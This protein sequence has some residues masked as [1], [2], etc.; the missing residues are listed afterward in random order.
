M[1]S[2]R[3]DDPAPPHADAP[4]AAAGRFTVV[5]PSSTLVILAL[6]N[7]FNYVDR[8][9]L[10][11]LIPLLEAPVAEGGL[12]LSSTEA[13]LLHTA[14]MI[15]HSVAS[16]PL[17][18]LADR[19][20]RTRVI[21]I[22]V[23]LWSLATAA[24]GLAR[25]YSELFIARAAVGIGEAAYAPAASALISERFTPA[26]RARALGVFQ[27]G[28]LVGTA[29]GVVTGGVVASA[30]GWRTAF[31]IVGLPGLI[32]TA[33]AL[34]IYE[35]PRPRVARATARGDGPPVDASIA[36]QWKTP[37]AR[38][39]IVA[40]N[41]AGV[42]ITFFVGAVALWGIAFLL[43]YHF[44]GDKSHLDEATMLFGLVGT[45][46]G[47]AGALSGSIVADRIER[48]RPG[49]GRLTAVGVGALVGAPCAA[50]ALITP[51]LWLALGALAISVYFVSWY[52]GPILAALHDVVAP[53]H[54]AAATGT[55]LFLVHALGDGISP[56]IVGVLADAISLRV[57]L[58]I[59]LV[60]MALGG[61]VAL[62]AVRWSVQVAEAKRE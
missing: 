41:A 32:L 26:Q 24:A 11:P 55:Y 23:G 3:P 21:A 16:I 6:I 48:R 61:V 39:A 36:L 47:I 42:L 18:I 14:F 17:G 30:F 12:G 13:G 58:L 59:A 62:V 8:Q 49:A 35:R 15:V 44:D 53:H 29:V 54:R 19:W 31:F 2:P 20:L 9:V 33:L 45:V 37:G 56:G 10:A 52:V 60:P 46:A 22:G 27:L 50:I 40:I 4:P 5:T 57:G 34:L 43:R 25:N 38:A 28:M 7:F 51:N 1:Q